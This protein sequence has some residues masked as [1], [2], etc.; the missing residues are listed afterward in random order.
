MAG[1]GERGQDVDSALGGQRRVAP[2]PATTREVSQPKSRVG[3]E[4]SHLLPGDVDVRQR[5]AVVELERPVQPRRLRAGGVLAPAVEVLH[6]DAGTRAERAAPQPGPRAGALPLRWPHHRPCLGAWETPQAL[7]VT[8]T[9]NP[10]AVALAC[11]YSS[12]SVLLLRLAAVASSTAVQG[13][14][15]LCA[16]GQVGWFRILIIGGSD[17]NMVLVVLVLRYLY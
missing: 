15:S 11:T 5:A 12:R 2:L 8:L 17:R 14:S 6:P 9:C 3:T 4:R 7:R 10:Q 1:V 13:T 16:L